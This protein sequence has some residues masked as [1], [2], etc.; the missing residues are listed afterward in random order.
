MCDRLREQFSEEGCSNSKHESRHAHGLDCRST[1]HATDPC[2]EALIRN[3]YIPI[4]PLDAR[5]KK[6]S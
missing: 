2:R 6:P 5:S 4:G 1:I 3:P